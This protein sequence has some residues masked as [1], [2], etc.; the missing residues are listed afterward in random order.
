MTEQE[1]K[2]VG[3]LIEAME[4]KDRAEEGF[5]WHLE[6]VEDPDRRTSSYRKFTIAVAA[7]RDA[8]R[9]AEA[10]WVQAPRAA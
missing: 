6:H 5:Y 1:R 7:Y 9:A 3:D 2:I 8:R 10:L 4:N